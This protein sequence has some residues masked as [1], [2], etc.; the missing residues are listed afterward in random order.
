MPAVTVRN[1]PEAVRDELAARAG[2]S[3]RSLQEYLRTELIA[4]A[5]R[6]SAEEL[7]ARVRS[8][9]AATGSSLRP[10]QILVLRDQ[11]RQ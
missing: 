2:A 7:V 5:A 6:P 3:G 4:L 9:K 8:R 10:E 11:G 1:V